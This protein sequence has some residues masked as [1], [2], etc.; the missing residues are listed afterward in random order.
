MSDPSSPPERLAIPACVG[1][2]EMSR[3][4]TCET[5]C[6]ELKL[7]VVPAA[8]VDA[9]ADA[10]REILGCISA[11]RPTTTELL[12][13]LPPDDGWEAAYLA[14]QD[15]ARRGLA[16]RV[17]DRISAYV[18]EEPAEPVVVW[19]C[20]RCGGIDAPQPCLGIC[21]W[22]TS[23]WARAEGYLEA[24]ARIACEYAAERRLRALVERIAHTTP[25]PGQHRRS[26][27]AFSEEAESVVSELAAL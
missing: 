10:E 2:G 20:P 16:T 19:W 26:W 23:D 9:L 5:G 11:L 22:R 21:V 1:C 4:G 8:T 17:D 3:P 7:L 6:L 24:S 18:R 27:Q 13:V 12:N 25:R 14:L 15:V